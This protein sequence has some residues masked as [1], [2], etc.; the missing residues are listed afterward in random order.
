MDRDRPEVD[1]ESGRGRGTVGTATARGTSNSVS[2]LKDLSKRS[3]PIGSNERSFPSR[4]AAMGFAYYRW[5]SDNLD[6]TSMPDKLKLPTRVTL[7]GVA[8]ANGWARIE[9]GQHFASD[10]LAGAAIGNFL[11]SFMQEAF[12][13]L[14]PTLNLT[15]GVDPGEETHVIGL[16]WRP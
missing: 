3:R 14:P 16:E 11:T 10:V 7:A 1:G 5:A 4:H 13:G 2:L 9:S 12:L 6:A 15:A 8:F